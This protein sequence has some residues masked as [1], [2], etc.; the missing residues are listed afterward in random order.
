MGYVVGL[1]L[2]KGNTMTLE[3]INTVLAQ[4]G[5][6]KFIDENGCISGTNVK[7]KIKQGRLRFELFDKLIMS[8]APTQKTIEDFC[9][10]YW[11]WTK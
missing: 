10:Y 4:Y 2:R 5:K 7:I 1:F 8:G 6:G 3:E 9:E 11:Y